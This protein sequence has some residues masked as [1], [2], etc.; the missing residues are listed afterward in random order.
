MFIV[1]SLFIPFFLGLGLLPLLLFPRMFFDESASQANGRSSSI[2]AI[3]MALGFLVDYLLVLIVQDIANALAIAAALSCLGFLVFFLKNRQ[4]L[5]HMFKVGWPVAAVFIYVVGLYAIPILLDPIAAWDA[6]S[7]WFLHGKMIYFNKGLYGASFE[8]F[9]EFSHLDYP[10]LVPVLAGQ[11]AYLVGFWNEYLPKASLLALILPGILGLVSFFERRRFAWLFLIILL[12]F[13]QGWLL[14]DGY[15][16][17]YLALYGALSLLFFGRWLKEGSAI[18]F[19]GG[20]VFAGVALNL[21]NEGMLFTLCIATVLLGVLLLRKRPASHLASFPLIQIGASAVVPLACFLFW[22]YRKMSWGL[23]NDL[24]LGIGSLERIKEHLNIEALSLLFRAVLVEASVG[25]AL[26]LFAACILIAI[27]LRTRISVEQLFPLLVG[28]FYFLGIV[29]VY[30]ATPADL[31]WHLTMSATRTMMPVVLAIF[32]TIF[33]V[34]C[35]IEGAG[36]DD[37]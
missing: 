21:K 11:V 27:I 24:R 15:M 1:L 5:V 6:R 14:W 28:I 17:G 8:N 20:F 18:D 7:I 33:F 29:T 12:P 16:D 35:A 22:S 34:I 10:K 37:V 36:K 2:L 13:S 3:V 31:A 9:L 32:T 26:F 19:A 4:F 25:K 30:L 23:E